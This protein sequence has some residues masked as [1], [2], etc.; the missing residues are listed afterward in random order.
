MI[1]LAARL[2]Y[3]QHRSTLGVVSYKS[4][5]LIQS[6][7]TSLLRITRKLQTIPSAVGIIPSLLGR[8]SH[9]IRAN[10]YWKENLASRISS[11]TMSPFHNRI[12]PTVFGEGSRSAPKLRK[13]LVQTEY[14]MTRKP[15]VWSS[16]VNYRLY[17]SGRPK[18]H[19]C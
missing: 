3:T 12:H 5:L 9:G 17:N 15:G 4:P 16:I 7:C 19:S 8:D 11:A 1:S 2:R 14:W 6:K 10:N 18:K 13:S